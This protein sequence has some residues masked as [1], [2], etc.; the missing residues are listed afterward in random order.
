MDN[1]IRYFVDIIVSALASGLATHFL[2]PQLKRKQFGQ[3]IREDGPQAH[4]VKQG[5]PT[6]G[7]L[8]IFAALVFSSV[9][10]GHFSLDIVIMLV[11]TALFGFIGFIDDYIKFAK[12][13]NLG[14]RAWQKLFLQILFGSLVAIYVMNYSQHGS[15]VWIPFYNE[16]VSLG[17]LYIPF[18]AFIMV[19][20]ANAV[21]LTDGLDGLSSGVTAIVA[22]CFG[23]VSIGFGQ[24]SSTI[25]SFILMGACLGFLFHNRYPAKIFMGDTG[26]MSLGGAVAV[27]A[28]MGKAELLLPIAGFIYVMEALSVIIQVG[29]YKLRGKRVF[30][31]APIHHHFEIGGMREYRV[32]HMFWAITAIMSLIAYMSTIL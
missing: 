2:I 27:I 26:S 12:K 9:I 8:A 1:F 32:V 3:F 14:L 16:Y 17:W 10:L 31:M 24:T 30:R 28:I 13:Q 11:V 19:A 21:N 29:S 15:Q 5:T 25:Y 20:M 7:G 23:A 18:V 4:L 22:L 6:M